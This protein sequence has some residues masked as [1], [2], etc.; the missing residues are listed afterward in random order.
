MNI[1]NYMKKEGRALPV[2]LLVDVSGSMT[3][4]KIETV[5]IALKEMLNA[6]RKIENPWDVLEYLALQILCNQLNR[7]V[8]FATTSWHVN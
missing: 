7:I 8:S 4:Q 2:F 6:F 1:S 3:G 5:N